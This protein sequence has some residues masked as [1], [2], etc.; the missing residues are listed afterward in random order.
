MYNYLLFIIN[1]LKIKIIF[2]FN[3]NYAFVKN[4]IKASKNYNRLYY[5]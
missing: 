3:L 2:L 1:H 5:L 4:N